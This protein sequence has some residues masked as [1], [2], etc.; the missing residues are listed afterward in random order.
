MYFA[1]PWPAM[2]MYFACPWP[3][4]YMYFACPWPAMYMYFETTQRN[5]CLRVDDQEWLP[6]IA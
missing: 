2:Y 1:C 4:M 6:E 3:A 5:R